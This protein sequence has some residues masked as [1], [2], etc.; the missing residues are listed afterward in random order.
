[1]R[2]IA[3]ACADEYRNIFFDAGVMLILF[4]AILIYPF[5]YPFPYSAEVLKKVPVGVVDL[6][7]SQLSRRLIRMMDAHEM[8]SVTAR[9]VSLEEAEDL[10]YKGDIKG[11]VVIPSRFE[12]DIMKG[13]QARV[14]AY[15]DAG[16]FLRYR[17]VLTGVLYST[18]TLSAG[19]AVKR[20]TAKGIPRQQ[21]MI[22]RD[23]LPLLQ[24]PL[25]NPAGGYATYAVPPVLILILQ[26]TLLIGIGMVGGTKRERRPDN[27]VS[28]IS[29]K[30]AVG[31][32]SLLVG[33]VLA[34]FSIYLVHVVYIAAILFRF[35]RFPQR[36]TLVEVILF[37]TPFLFSVISL[38][39]AASVLFKT[40]EAS[41]TMLLFTSLPVLFLAGFSWPVESIPSWLRFFSLFIPS[42]SG[43]DGFLR[44]VC[45]GASL[46][47]VGPQWVIL[48]GLSISY[49]F[50]AWFFLR[51]SG[52]NNHI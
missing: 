15:C 45:M 46:K 39:L 20:M 2:S 40:R 31:R 29:E 33:K 23:P 37:L 11:I 38:G 19:V 1:M 16:Y 7:R 52:R 18:G 34:Y 10:F 6:D 36:G 44:I 49:F 47:E 4:G 25:F 48:W 17:Q 8:L 3:R 14:A 43:I 22:K 42:T 21:A 5:F 28:P 32:V 51:L 26:Q 27:G 9:P 41:M 13:R 35:Y 50:M 24:V 30:K 12:R